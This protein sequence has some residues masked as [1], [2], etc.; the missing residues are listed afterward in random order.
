MYSV[1][2]N[3]AMGFLMA[4]TLCFCLGDL[5]AIV[6]TR[7]GYPSIQVFY[8]ATKSYAATNVLVTIF[9][10]NLTACCISEVATTSR[11]LW[12]FARDKGVPFSGWFAH[13]RVQTLDYRSLLISHAGPPYH[14]RS[15]SC[16]RR[17]GG[18]HLPRVIDQHWFYHGVE[19]YRLPWCRS[20]VELLLYL[21][22][23]PSVATS[24][25]STVA[26]S[27]MVSWSVWI[28]D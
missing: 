12:S 22:R 26:K 13:V 20:F 15:P 3:G 7:T 24:E 1:Y 10:I 25:G 28:G 21:N 14:A 16:Y 4:V 17:L 11:Q 8:N 23:L 9:T 5:A 2:L 27:P 18:Y 6:D 19:R